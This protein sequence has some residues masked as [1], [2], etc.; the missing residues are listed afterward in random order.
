[1][2]T[3][4]RT[5]AS[6]PPVPATIGI[7]PDGDRVSVSIRGELDLDAAQRFRPDL[8]HAL[9]Y[10]VSGIDL[11][12]REVEF[13]D[14]SGLNLLLSLHR[15]AMEQCKTVTMRSGSRAVER[16]LDLT[17][18]RELFTPPN[19][20]GETMTH[21][22]APDGGPCVGTDPHTGQDL[23]TLVAQLRRAMQTRP[24]ID[25]ARGILMA[26]FSLSPEAAWQVLVTASQNTNTK[27]HR[28]A[29]DLVGTV[30]GDVLPAGVQEHLAAAVAKANL[31]GRSNGS[32]R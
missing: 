8:R 21:P 16:V 3:S 27:L 29:H 12:L 23:H 24:T 31:D 9:G 18:S 13:C 5:P 30:Q 26:S 11:H 14:C 1:M 22:A 7:A 4:P 17:G 32:G 15:R 20:D 19:P 6:V 28:L 25:L 10:S 2:P